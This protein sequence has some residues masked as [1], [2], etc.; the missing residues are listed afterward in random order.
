M[1]IQAG[2]VRQNTYESYPE[3]TERELRVNRRGELVVMDFWTQLALDGRLFHMQIGTEDAPVASTAS[4]D[5]AM[6]W[7]LV[8]G[9][10]GT[11]YIPCFVDVTLALPGNTSATGDAMFEIDR[12][13]A[14]YTSG[15]TAFVPENLR[16]DRPR[17]SAAAAAYVGTDITAAAKTAVPGSLEV[18]RKYL[19]NTAISTT[20]EASDFNSNL[21]PLYSCHRNA[22]V[23]VVGVG[24]MVLHFGAG[25]ADVNGYGVMQWGEIPTDNVT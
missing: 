16:T 18:G 11:T 8:D 24:S 23:V 3:G 13:K 14:R 4:I 7:A 12:A 6:V 17:V 19:F 20:N 25:T 1:A 2:K 5:D 21:V 10:T 22:P 9:A 15:G